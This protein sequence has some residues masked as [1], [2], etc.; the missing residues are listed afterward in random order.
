M[1][2]SEVIVIILHCNGLP[3]R[4]IKLSSASSSKQ[5]FKGEYNLKIFLTSKQGLSLT[6]FCLSSDSVLWAPATLDFFQVLFLSAETTLSYS[7]L[8]LP[9]VNSTVLSDFVSVI[10]SW[11][12]QFHLIYSCYPINNIHTFNNRY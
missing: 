6:D 7:H 8:P 1:N 12:G 11:L 3:L 9:K 2:I 4:C 10:T 5:I